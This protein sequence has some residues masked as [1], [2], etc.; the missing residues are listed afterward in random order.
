MP[1]IAEIGEFGAGRAV[2]DI[3]AP[4][5]GEDLLGPWPLALSPWPLALGSTASR[6]AGSASMREYGSTAVR[7][8]ASANPMAAATM[9][10]DGRQR[11][12]S[13]SPPDHRRSRSASFRT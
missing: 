8:T 9:R 2:G 11:V 6:L 1:R 7:S 5:G 3:G 13:T 10:S 12:V 4:T